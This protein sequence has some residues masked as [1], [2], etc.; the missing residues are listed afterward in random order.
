[1]SQYKVDFRIFK[2]LRFY[3]QL[4]NRPN[5]YCF[6]VSVCTS[7]HSEKGPYAFLQHISC[8][9]IQNRFRLILVIG[10]TLGSAIAQAATL[11][12]SHRGD[13]K[14]E[15]IRS[16][17]NQSPISFDMKRTAEKTKRQRGEHR[18]P[19]AQQRQ[20]AHTD[21][22]IRRRLHSLHDPQELGTGGHTST[23]IAR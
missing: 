22:E 13:H 15:T 14:K 17:K 11:L 9:K 6:L 21:T 20:G 12:A 5:Y 3:N 23:Q 7:A 1:M 4:S 18:R 10:S 8:H 16:G 2:V 19:V